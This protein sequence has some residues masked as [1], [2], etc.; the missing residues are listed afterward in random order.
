MFIPEAKAFTG[1]FT[2]GGGSNQLLWG[3]DP[4]NG[5]HLSITDGDDVTKA[6]KNRSGKNSNKRGESEENHP[7]LQGLRQ[8]GRLKKWSWIFLVA[9]KH[10]TKN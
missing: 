6:W 9:V 10:V 5:L 1:V 2:S 8:V 7:R 4:S 3:E